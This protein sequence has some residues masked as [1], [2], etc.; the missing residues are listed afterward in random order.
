MGRKKGR[1]EKKRKLV[2]IEHLPRSKRAE[3]M[4]EPYVLM[5]QLIAD[6]H[7]HLSDA[8]IAIVWHDG[9]KAD[10]DGVVRLSEGRKT[11]EVSKEVAKYGGDFILMLNRPKWDSFNLKQRI[12]ML[13]AA[14]EMCKPE[15]DRDG[16]Q[17]RDGRDRPIW[18][19]RKPPLAIFPEVVRRCGLVMEDLQDLASI[20]EER[21]IEDRPLLDRMGDTGDD[22][23]QTVPM[24]E[25]A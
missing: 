16:E 22:A 24:T 23:P 6:H 15:L 2:L 4:P 13:D 18:R 1:K 17:K 8:D 7:D 21:L 20:I 9:W 12:Y 19:K 10:G 5:D 3:D 25:S 14:L 11:S